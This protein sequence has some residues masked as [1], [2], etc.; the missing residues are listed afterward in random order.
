MDFSKRISKIV[1]NLDS[2]VVIGLP[3]DIILLMSDIFST[4]FV[5]G[6]YHNLPRRKNIV[7]RETKDSLENLPPV[8]FIMFDLEKLENINFM[9]PKIMITRPK[10]FINTENPISK[11]YTKALKKASYD[12]VFRGKDY[13]IWEHHN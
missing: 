9:W 2:V 1:K 13:H 10:I 5:Y 7:F 11:E 3:D 8:S 4:V 12:V 6:E